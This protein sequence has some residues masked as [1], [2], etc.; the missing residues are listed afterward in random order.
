MD[1]FTYT[2][3]QNLGILSQS[4]QGWTKELNVIS[5]NGHPAKYDLREWSP[6][7]DKM[8]KGITLTPQEMRLLQAAIAT[9]EIATPAE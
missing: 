1:N 4:N 2:I 8:T 9:I 7:H 5:W 3:E 6:E